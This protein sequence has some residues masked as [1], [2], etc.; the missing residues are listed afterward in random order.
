[1]NILSFQARKGYVFRTNFFKNAFK[2][3]YTILCLN[4]IF[5]YY[6]RISTAGENSTFYKTEKLFPLSRSSFSHCF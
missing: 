3:L 2:M 5:L 1:M 4:S 6:C